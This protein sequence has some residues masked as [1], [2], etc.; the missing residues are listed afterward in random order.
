MV[1]FCHACTRESGRVRLAGVRALRRPGTHVR[2]ERVMDVAST[3]VS[4][5][6]A[7]NARVLL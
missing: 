7:C 6:R 3:C 5:A 2:S 1:A 4:A